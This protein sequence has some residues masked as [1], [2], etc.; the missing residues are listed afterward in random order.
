MESNNCDSMPKDGICSC[1]TFKQYV[2]IE[3]AR[4]AASKIAEMAWGDAARELME[5]R[6]EI[7]NGI[8]KRYAPF[9]IPTR[10]EADTLQLTD[11]IG[12]RTQGRDDY[13]T[14]YLGDLHGDVK[15]P[16]NVVFIPLEA[17]LSLRE[18]DREKQDIEEHRNEIEKRVFEDIVL[19]A[20]RGEIE[21]A[22]PEIMPYLEFR[23]HIFDTD[24]FSAI[25]RQNA[26]K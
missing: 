14:L 20:Q 22:L 26:K 10:E 11:S 15:N 8:I 12:L 17:M 6:K 3:S 9:V 13:Y 16:R 23:P 21:A 24:Y 7:I 2:T 19:L 18:L 4:K 5:R 1:G 25:L